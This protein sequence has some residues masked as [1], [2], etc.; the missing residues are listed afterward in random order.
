MCI[1]PSSDSILKYHAFEQFQNDLYDYF[2]E[3]ETCEIETIEK[4]LLKNFLKK[5]TQQRVAQITGISGRT[6]RKKVRN[7]FELLQ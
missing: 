4:L 2:Y 7:G 1:Q 3:N 6:I 5:L